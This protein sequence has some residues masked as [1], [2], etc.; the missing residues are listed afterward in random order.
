MSEANTRLLIGILGVVAILCAGGAIVL[1]ALG[2]PVPSELAPITTGALGTI[3]GVLVPR[4][5]QKDG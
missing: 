2:R 3:G 1:A 4:N 5:P